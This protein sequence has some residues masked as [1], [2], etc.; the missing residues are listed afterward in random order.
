MIR[1]EYDDDILSVI[2][3]IN[4]ELANHNLKLV[5]EDEIHDGYEIFYLKKTRCNHNWVM[6]GH[7]T[8]D[9]ICSKCYSRKQ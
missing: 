9:P 7:N 6:D 3:K 5:V 8:D 1:I 4:S 2:E